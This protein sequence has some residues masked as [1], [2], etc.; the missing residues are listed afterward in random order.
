MLFRSLNQENLVLTL[1]PVAELYRLYLN[2]VRIGEAGTFEDLNA[3]QLARSRSFPVP[4]RALGP[5]PRLQLA[6]RC[7]RPALPP[8]LALFRGGSYVVA[9]ARSAPAGIP[10]PDQRLRGA[11]RLRAGTRSGRRL[12]LAAHES[13][14]IAHGCRGRRQRQRF[15]GRDAGFG[16][17][18]DLAQ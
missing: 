9:E 14:R 7:R 3:A 15:A 2:G 13:G 11:S 8:T 4:P 5:G 1:G 17:G 18:G 6:I 10:R 12:P 16:R